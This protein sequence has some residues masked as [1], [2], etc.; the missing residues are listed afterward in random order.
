MEMQIDDRPDLLRVRLS[1]SFDELATDWLNVMESRLARAPVDVFFDLSGVT[2]I[3]SKGLGAIF[4]LTKRVEE[5]DRTAFF[6]AL[7]APVR[8]VFELAGLEHILRVH[9]DEAEAQ[10]EL[11]R[12]RA[13]RS[14]PE[15]E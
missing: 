10:R 6:C 3:D 5:H 11:E 12:V 4:A 2:Y 13:F 8:E 14:G 15:A 7:S 9:V 1:G